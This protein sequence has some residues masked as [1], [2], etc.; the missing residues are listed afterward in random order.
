[1]AQKKNIRK[2]RKPTAAKKAAVRKP[3]KTFTKMVNQVIQSKA[4]DKQTF[5]T[6][7]SSLLLFNSAISV[8]GDMLQV[9]PGMIKGINENERIGEKVMGKSLSVRGHVMLPTINR[10][11][12]EPGVSNVICRLFCVSLKSKS[13]FTDAIG[14][15]VPLQSLLLKGGA[16]TGFTGLLSDIYAPVNRNIFT[17]H[18][19]KKF[20]LSQ[21]YINTL[22]AA[23]TGIVSVNTREAVKFFNFQVKCKQVMKYDDS[24]ATGTYP[25]NFAPI[26][27]LGYSFLDGSA[28]DTISTNVGMCYDTIFTYE[29]Q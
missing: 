20:Y 11:I 27:L 5:H 17:V 14:T 10:G 1:M 24:Q 28:P 19:D 26:M 22:G 8:V 21:D 29:D 9:M 3:I 4:E 23:T 12:E 13:L 15:S 25:V 7:G 16:A 18:Y 6:S 2:N